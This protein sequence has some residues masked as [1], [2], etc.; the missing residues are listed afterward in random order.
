MQQEEA[1]IKKMLE[2]REGIPDKYKNYF[3][4]L[5]D[6]VSNAYEIAEKARSKGIDPISSV[7]ASSAYDVADRVEKLLGVKVGERLSELLKQHRTERAALIIAEEVAAGR[8]GHLDKEDAIELAI[9]VG[10]AVVTDGVT[11]APIQGV[12]SVKIKK[13]ND[14]TNYVAVYFAGP[15]RSAGGTEAAFTLVIADHVRK[16]LGLA[17]YKATEQEV[18]RF[19]EELRVYERDVSNFQYVVSDDDIKYA[20]LHLPIE[21]T[22]VETDP[23]EVVAHRGLSRIETDRVRGG[24]LR[25][26]ND[27]VIGRSRKL[28]KLVQDLG[29]VDWDWLAKL[30]GGMQQGSD[31]TAHAGSHFEEVISGRPVLSFPKSSGGFRLRYGRCYNTGLSTIGIH[32]ATAAILDYPVVPGTQVKVD[33]PGKAATIAFVDTIEPPLVRLD[34]G[35]VLRV[36]DYK[37]AEELSKRVEK[38]IYLGDVLISYGDFLENNHILLPSAYVEELWA[39]EL[40]D[41]I[42]SSSLHEI[43]AKVGIKKDRLEE[44]VNKPL[45]KK[46]TFEEALSLSLKLGLPI[47]PSYNFYW[48]EVTP[49][50]ILKLRKEIKVRKENELMVKKDEELKEIL[51]RLGVE[52]ELT[53]EGYMIK[54]EQAKSLHTLLNLEK[55]EIPQS[56]TTF[57]LIK[58]I[59][60]ISVR[61]K[62]STYVGIRV[63]RPEKAIQRKMKPL[64]HILFPVGL[65]GG[66]TRDL[67]RASVNGKISVELVDS[68]CKNCGSYSPSSKCMNCGSDVKIFLNCPICGRRLENTVCPTCNLS[69]VGY[70]RISFDLKNA[71]K[72][73]EE[74]VGYKPKP[75][76]KGVQGLTNELKYPEL[77]EKGILRNKYSLSVYKDGTIRFDATNC[78][79]T[80]FKPKQ[81]GVSVSKLK[82]LGYTHDFQGNELVSDEQ[83][84]ELYHQDVILPKSCLKHLLNVSK[85]IDDLLEKVYGLERYY[86]A[87]KPEDL[88]GKLVVGLAPHTSVGIIGRIIGFTDSQT[89]LA[90]PYWHSAK[91]RDCD[92]DGDSIILLLDVLL[93]FS[94]KFLPEQIG[95][96]MDA[97]LLIQPMVLPEELQRQVHN[98]DATSNYPISFYE[99]T[100]KHIQPQD[101]EH[102]M[103]TIRAKIKKGEK[104]SGFGFTHE[105]SLMIASVNRSKY[106][107]LK[108]IPDKIS[109]QIQLAKKIRAVKPEDVVKSVLKTHI[110]PDIVG[111]IKAYTSQSFRCKSCGSSYRR[112][113]LKGTCPSCGGELQL[114]V[115]KGSVEKYLRIGLKLC[116]EFDVGTYLRNRFELLV[117]EL[118]LNFPKKKQLELTQFT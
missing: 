107:L 75:P 46:P 83:L 18:D 55:K 96:L 63:G 45:S 111:N 97:P 92:G 50:Q 73:A 82:E 95:G 102:L 110:L 93:N 59:S 81:I 87:S 114:T 71:L 65:N 38:V 44:L 43:S 104:F 42:E 22:G 9:R 47:H 113:P 34:D 20:L 117:K 85:F 77:I 57:E 91:R 90:H 98:F 52:H 79:L 36:R 62:S 54:D 72:N 17:P 108:S 116:E 28:L 25:V 64:V 16:V 115:T 56:L 80:H 6:D 10:L 70:S 32:P 74:K 48:E 2:E 30:K 29:I 103:N 12:S 24:A 41:I 49:A 19:I 67:I 100:L 15:I 118:E 60:G 69:G 23:V 3:F 21:P 8:F 27:G 39:Q 94:K 58:K 84:V 112:I 31:D 109:K 101:I 13:N 53:K 89:C 4:N 66:A 40:K 61:P 88:I 105:T 33:L 1:K 78:P 37:Q 51:E 76:L 11:V 14:G 7:E 99:A 106:S 35:K 26:V 68:W 5:L 86:N